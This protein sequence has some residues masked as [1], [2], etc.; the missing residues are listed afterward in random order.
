M[1]QKSMNWQTWLISL[2]DKYLHLT[3]N[4]DIYSG[5]HPPPHFWQKSKKKEKNLEG[6]TGEKGK[7]EMEEKGG[8]NERE[9][10]R[11]GNRRKKGE[12]VLILIPCLI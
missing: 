5:H 2:N 12:I 8:K 4:M 1:C 7:M 3:L 9:R 6:I 10:R 11:K